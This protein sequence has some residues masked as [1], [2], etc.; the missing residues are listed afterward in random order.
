MTSDMWDS[1]MEVDAALFLCALEATGPQVGR[2]VFVNMG[3][4]PERMCMW[5]DATFLL[6]SLDVV[7]A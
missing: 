7:L 2:E 5:Y 6:P 3:V 4:L 1:Q